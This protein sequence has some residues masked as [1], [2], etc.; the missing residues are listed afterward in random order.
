MFKKFI[1]QYKRGQ[2]IFMHTFIVVLVMIAFVAAILTAGYNDKP[3][4]NN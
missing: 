2:Y 4:K 3:G 1:I